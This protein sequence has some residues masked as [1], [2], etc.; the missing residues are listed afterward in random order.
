MKQI[1]DAENPKTREMA[2][3]FYDQA[4]GSFFISSAGETMELP[5]CVMLLFGMTALLAYDL[6]DD[7]GMNRVLDALQ[8]AGN[9]LREEFKTRN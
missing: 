9:E 3:L 4:A 5:D 8:N 6:L 7:A 2:T 1:A